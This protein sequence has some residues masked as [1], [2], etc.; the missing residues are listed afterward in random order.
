MAYDVHVRLGSDETG[1]VGTAGDALPGDTTARPVV[2]FLTIKPA[3]D[4]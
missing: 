4:P 2:Q 3:Q 1:P